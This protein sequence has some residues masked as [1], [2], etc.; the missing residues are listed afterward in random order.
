MS[1]E[2]LDLKY[3][4]VLSTLE[5]ISLK[6]DGV[7]E[8]LNDHDKKDA[9]F[10]EWKRYQEKNVTNLSKTVEDTGLRISALENYKW[11]LLGMSAVFSV[12]CTIT[13]N[14]MGAK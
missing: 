10:N 8:R 3:N 14:L 12:I 13:L 9:A 6:L 5:K 2:S 4:L 7:L 1:E 11:F